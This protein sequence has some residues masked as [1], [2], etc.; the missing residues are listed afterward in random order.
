MYRY[1]WA[2]T[3]RTTVPASGRACRIRSV[4]L[5]VRMLF[6]SHRSHYDCGADCLSHHVVL[7]EM[8]GFNGSRCCDSAYISQKL[9]SHH[10]SVCHAAAVSWAVFT[11]VLTY[12]IRLIKTVRA[13]P[14]RTFAG[15]RQTRARSRLSQWVG[16]TS[17]G[18]TGGRVPSWGNLITS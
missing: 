4:A 7:M 1:N 3:P 5:A 10:V 17:R 13:T 9:T 16:T 15:V 18:P 11:Y 12:E 14:N 2:D 6:T 8:D